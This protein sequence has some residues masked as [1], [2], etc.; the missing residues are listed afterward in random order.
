LEILEAR[1]VERPNRF[2][3]V[4]DLEGDR[5]HIHIN[6]PGRLKELL[7]P[8]ARVF[9]RREH[10]PGRKTRFTLVA[11]E[12]EGV[13]VS[14]DSRLPNRFVSELLGNRARPRFQ[15]A[16]DVRAEVQVGKSRL[17][18][19]FPLDGA[20]WFV[21]VKGCTLVRNGVALFPD[22]PTARGTR[23]MRELVSLREGGFAAGV[24]FVIQRPDARVFAPNR[25]TD[26]AFAEAF[27]RAVKQGVMTCA[28]STE[29]VLGRG[30]R[31]LRE[32]PIRVVG[33]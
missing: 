4:V 2:L 30:L 16:T 31:F 20:R 3:G 27:E 24:F 6:D 14:V 32:I 7:I 23:H 9:L 10:G 8:G 25:E 33:V 17:D 18:F 28:L 26:P 29:L 12:H 11:V 22:A 1:F 5:A 19:S 21:E 13:L 15:G